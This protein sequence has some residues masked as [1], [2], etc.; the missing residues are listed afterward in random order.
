[1][2][3]KLPPRPL[4]ETILPVCL[5]T[6]VPVLLPR[7]VP[8]RLFALLQSILLLNPVG[9][10]VGVQDVLNPGLPPIL[11]MRFPSM[12]RR[13]EPVLLLQKFFQEAL[14][15]FPVMLPVIRLK[16]LLLIKPFIWN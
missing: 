9:L 2:F 4:Q 15:I 16:G 10:C 11:R 6:Y 8:V 12:R 14:I 3:L 7:H 5:I 1:M 13:K